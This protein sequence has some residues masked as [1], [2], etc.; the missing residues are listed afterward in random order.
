MMFLCQSDDDKGSWNKIEKI[1][2]VVT[3]RGNVQIMTNSPNNICNKLY[4]L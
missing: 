1:L 3:E 4:K 2:Q